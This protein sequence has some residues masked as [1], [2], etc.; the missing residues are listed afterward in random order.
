[1]NDVYR[2]ITEQRLPLLEPGDHLDQKT[3]HARYEARPPGTRAGLT[4]NNRYGLE[5]RGGKRAA[6][7]CR[8]L[9]KLLGQSSAMNSK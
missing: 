3:F 5:S 4:R 2:P 9:K 8:T 7:V 1:M 6:F